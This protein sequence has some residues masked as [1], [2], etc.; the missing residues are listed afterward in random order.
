MEAYQLMLN[1]GYMPESMFEG[2]I[3]LIAKEE[4][5][6][7]DIRKRRPITILNGCSP[8]GV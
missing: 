3:L 8:S 5:I 2:L 7:I 4:G 6:S 1:T